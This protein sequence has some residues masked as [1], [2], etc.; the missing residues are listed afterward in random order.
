MVDERPGL[1]SNKQ[2]KY[3][4]REHQPSNETTMRRRI[5]RRIQGALADFSLLYT[6]H[7]DDEI[8][9]TFERSEREQFFKELEGRRGKT[10]LSGFVP[11]Q[12]PEKDLA[13]NVIPGMRDAISYFYLGTL[14][15]GHDEDNFAEIVRNA[16]KN[17]VEDNDDQGRIAEVTVEIEPQLRDEQLEELRERFLNDE[18]LSSDELDALLDSDPSVTMDA[19]KNSLT[20]CSESEDEESK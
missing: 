8:E 4:L 14:S 3:L 17:A 18:P 5:R 13:D 15:R 11:D 16:V 20:T 7:E 2:R 19:I 10:G 9:M 6:Y 1:L 12:E